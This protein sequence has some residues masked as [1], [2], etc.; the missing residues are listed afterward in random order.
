[1]PFL[2]ALICAGIVLLCC[3]GCQS[4]S[5]TGS[6]DAEN[7]D[8]SQAGADDGSQSPTDEQ[9]SSPTETNPAGDDSDAADNNGD[10]PT[11]PDET[12][13]EPTLSDSQADT[14]EPVLEAASVVGKTVAAIMPAA[15]L[16]DILFGGGSFP[17]CPN[18][19][20][21]LGSDSILA[22]LVYGEGCGVS[23]Y[24][25]AV[26]AG[27]ID[28]D[29]FYTVSAIEFLFSDLSV[30]QEAL[31]GRLGGGFAAGAEQVTFAI[32][33]SVTLVNGTTINGNATVIGE[34]TSGVL[35]IRDA[36]LTI[37]ESDQDALQV[38]YENVKIDASA[39]ADFYPDA[40]TAHYNL[41][42]DEGTGQ[43]DTMT[44]SFS[45]DTA[46]DSTVNVTVND[47][48]PIVYTPK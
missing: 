31:S 40:G 7:S 26:F 14:I 20:A 32:N 25:E 17:A 42:N 30:N 2:R 44:L 39:A 27:T 21:D 36:T 28:G 35:E 11:Q 6:A 15:E 19:D 43:P 9:N 29:Y 37:N 18:I 48:M 23:L 4:V 47:A 41:T 8:S 3:Q 24:P 34:A 1:M 13:N 5:S 38:V 45:A 46:T 10:T 33:V 12:G 16:P 22:T